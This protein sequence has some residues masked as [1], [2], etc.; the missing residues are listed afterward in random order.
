[1]AQPFTLYVMQSA[2]TDIGYTHPQEQLREMYVEYYDRVLEFCRQTAN[3]PEEHRF[4]WTCETFWQVQHYLNE[5]PEREE[6]FLRYVRSGQIEITALYAHFT[7]LID[8][9]AYRRGLQLAVEYCKK[10]DLPLRTAM[11]CDVNGWPWAVADLLAEYKIPYFISHLNLDM[12]TDPLGE[13]GS[14]PYEMLRT[15]WPED[16][17]PDAPF[18]IPKAFWWQG[19]QGGQVLHWLNDIYLLGNTLGLSS[20]KGFHEDKARYFTET[21]DNSLDDL[22]AIAQREVPLYI[23][24][25]RAHGY[26]YNAIIISSGGFFIDNSPPDARW[27]QVIERWNREHDEIRLRTA[28]VSEWFSALPTHGSQDYPSYQVAWPDS[29]AHGLGSCTARVAQ[30][31]RSQRRRADVEAL[32]KQA[33]TPRASAYFA[34]SLEEERLALEHTFGAWSTTRRPTSWLNNFEQNVKELFF[35]RSELYLNEAAGA[36]LHTGPRVKDRPPTLYAGGGAREAGEYLLHFTS[37]ELLPDPSSQVLRARDG[38]H[39]AFQREN[40]E[41]AQFVAMVPL[42]ARE[43]SSFELVTGQAAEKPMHFQMERQEEMLLIETVAWQ[44]RLDLRTGS[45]RSLLERASGQEW[46]NGAHEY[47]FGQ[48]VHERV[49]HPWGWRAVGNEQRFLALGVASEKLKQS[50]PEGAVFSRETVEIEGEPIV[51]RGAIFTEVRLQARQASFGQVQV[52]WRFY[53]HLPMLELVLDWD[54]PW[55][56]APEAG[57]VAFPFS[58]EQASL[59]LETGGGFFRPGSHESGGQLPGTCSSYYTIQ[60]AARI[61]GARG[62]R[63]WWLPLDAPLVMT[64]ELNYNRWE[65]EPW[66]WNGFLASMP[67]NHYWHT[68]FPVSQ[69]GPFRLRYRLVSAQSGSS[70]ELAIQ[71]AQP[72]EALGWH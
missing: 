19:P 54:K 56:K 5:R 46:V 12:G 39:Y 69:Q 37:E 6:E 31:R 17:R 3:E 26:P 29:W 50:Y 71:A 41:L 67:V 23:E 21:D 30:I 14:L 49:I 48:L 53:H 11:H 45:L 38:Q 51:V 2:H 43:L 63:G 22:Y 59:D 35:H 70:E 58:A 20:S 57:Y 10:H 27:C 52:G 7:D 34:R 44:A 72:V 66:N 40:D 62:M 13:R 16:L 65:T 42:P 36:A 64:N 8:E 15:H 47:G 25:L 55:S 4:K 9:D 32:V 61:Q 60:R 68:N 1:M 24:Q 18:R 33:N 28:T